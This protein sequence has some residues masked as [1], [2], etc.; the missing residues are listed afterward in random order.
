LLLQSE[1]ERFRTEETR[2]QETETKLFNTGTA[3]GTTFDTFKTRMKAV[4]EHL[5][6]NHEYCSDVWCQSLKKNDAELD[7][8]NMKV[9]YL[10]KTDGNT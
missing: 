9:R 5:F 3:S 4:L 8:V 1:E 10:S 6:N 7:D 2:L